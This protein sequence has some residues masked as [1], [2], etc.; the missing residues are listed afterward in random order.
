M[1]DVTDGRDFYGEG[2]GYNFFTGKDASPSFVTGKFNDEGLKDSLDHMSLTE[3][4]GVVSW[5][6][7]Y[8]S[9]DKYKFIG[10]LEGVYFDE[11]GKP[12]I[13][14]KIADGRIKTLQKKKKEL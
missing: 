7:F 14:K 9:H 12:T 8:R 1:Y 4:G 2:T 10:L 6:D 5:R 11:D 13:H 3:L